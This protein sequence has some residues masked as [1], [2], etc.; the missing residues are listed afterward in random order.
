MQLWIH[1]M[2]TGL[3]PGRVSPFGHPWISAHLRLPMAFRSLSRPSSAIGALAFSLRSS[4]L[5]LSSPHSL[6]RPLRNADPLC[7]RLVVIDPFGSLHNSTRL[8]SSFLFQTSLCSF[9]GALKIPRGE[10]PL[11]R[12]PS[13]RYSDCDSALSASL[14]SS[15][16]GLSAFFSFILPLSVQ[17]V[18]PGS[19]TV[20]FAC[21]AFASLALAPVLSP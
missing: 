18:R 21:S 12:E 14:A 5:D 15:A 11:P 9:Q 20:R 3:S 4:S 8:T 16:F 13:K 6:L 17:N 2:M 7:F 19:R 10:F 1:R